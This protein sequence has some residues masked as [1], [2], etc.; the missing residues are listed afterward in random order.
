VRSARL[1]ALVAV[2]LLGIAI[3]EAQASSAGVLGAELIFGAAP[4]EVNDVAI[5]LE[6]DRYRVTDAGASGVVA[7]SGCAATSD[8]RSV[9]CAA[10]G[11]NSIGALLL[12]G[13]DALLADA[14]VP[15]NV[16]GYDGVDRIT[17]G[18]GDD[19]FF[20]MEGGDIIHGRAGNDRMLELDDQ[21]NILDGGPGI[22]AISAGSG[23][24][25]VSGGPG[26]DRILFG[27]AG[28][29][30]IDGGDGDDVLDAGP[31]LAVFPAVDDGTPFLSDSDRLI[32][33]PGLDRVS[34][35][36]R[37]EPVRVSVGDGANDGE[38]GE[39]DDVTAGVEQLTGGAST[40]H[41]VGSPGD[42]AIDGFAGGDEIEGGPGDDEIDGGA[43]D[44]FADTLRGGTG[45]DTLA[46]RAG[47]DRLEGGDDTDRLVGDEGGD[48]LAG[49]AGPD[50]LD[51]GAGDDELDGGAGG[52]TLSGGAGIDTVRYGFR[53]A[54]IQVTI[55]GVADDGQVA[56]S[57]GGRTRIEEGARSSERD[58]VDA[59]NERVTASHSDDT[60]EGDRAANRLEGAAG[61]DYLNGV[62]GADTLSG[63]SA[64]DAIV[65]RDGSRDRVTCGAGSDYVVAD[66][67]DL[68]PRNTAACEYV[69]D[70]SRSVPRAR[71]DMMLRPHCA[72]GRDAELSPP[73]TQRGMPVAQPVL[74]PL[75]SRVD[76]L[77]CRVKLTVGVGGRRRLAGRLGRGSG[78]LRITQR[79]RAGGRLVTR[80][81]ATDCARPGAAVLVRGVAARFPKPR[82]QRRYG[83]IAFPTEMR[84][85][86]AVI[87]KGRG[88][89]TWSVD[90]RCGRT[91]TIRVTSGRL[92]VLD[93]GRDRRVVLEPGDPYTAVT[94]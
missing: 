32:G 13:D 65:S 4:G 59:T 25:E 24:D 72:R 42:D 12:D 27:G 45:N 64:D 70:Q 83:R 31:G 85:D 77:D 73:G 90:H 1:P 62:G 84:L 28:N 7:E 55:D 35:G 8:P 51:G 50:R 74:A 15:V 43:T 54:P 78:T 86:S 48:R 19:E 93:L 71:E 47:D 41:L 80:M 63:G 6:G 34:Y 23:P 82:Y 21:G 81:R 10:A 92:A 88:V 53:P 20:G 60:V 17:G 87:T 89:A 29:D 44:A 61:E 40:D 57:R 9:L 3:P 39:N 67:R 14:P 94:P 52:D 79:R 22:D 66:V 91:A 68:V 2:A 37:A 18:A 30:L 36:G 56:P 58:N 26:D 46:G 33:G 11:V 75:G 16:F 76:A 69:D 38:S 5:A 49:G